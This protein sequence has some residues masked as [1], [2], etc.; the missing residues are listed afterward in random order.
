M[1][2]KTIT[3]GAIIDTGEGGDK[4]NSRVTKAHIIMLRSAM[5]HAMDVSKPYPIRVG[6]ITMAVAAVLADVGYPQ[7]DDALKQRLYAAMAQDGQ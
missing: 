1:K 4:P 5:E 7:Y 6:Y 3:E 2:G